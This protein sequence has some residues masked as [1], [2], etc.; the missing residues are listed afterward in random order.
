VV[1]QFQFGT[2]AQW[3]K[4]V[5]ECLPNLAE[6][7]SQTLVRATTADSDVDLLSDNRSL[8]DMNFVSGAVVYLEFKVAPDTVL[9]A[10]GPEQAPAK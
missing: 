2:H 7:W 8:L 1:R 9:A 4:P 6:P 3:N 10:G 5:R